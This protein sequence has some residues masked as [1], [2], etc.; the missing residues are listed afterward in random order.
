[1]DADARRSN[2]N[3]PLDFAGFAQE[4]LRRSPAYREQHRA[5]ERRYPGGAPDPIWKEMALTW[6]L[7]FPVP[8]GRRSARCSGKLAGR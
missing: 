1:M 5:I 6:G 2:R 8:P 3:C 7:V 4:F